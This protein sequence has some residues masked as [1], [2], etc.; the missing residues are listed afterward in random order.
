[1]RTKDLNPESTTNKLCENFA[2]MGH[3]LEIFYTVTLDRRAWKILC[4]SLFVGVYRGVSTSEIIIEFS[5]I[6]FLRDP[7][8]KRYAESTG[9]IFKKTDHKN[10]WVNLG[11]DDQ[12]KTWVGNKSFKI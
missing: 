1:M 8:K 12:Y 2:L 10:T 6:D 11:S 4:L 7:D 9:L 3:H 5:E